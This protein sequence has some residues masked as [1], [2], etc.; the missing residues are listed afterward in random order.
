MHRLPLLDMLKRYSSRYPDEAEMLAR[1]RHLVESAPDCFQRTCRPGH[2]TGSAWV[3]SHD[4]TKCLLLHH[5]KL[6]RWLQPGG[7]ADGQTEIQQ[8][9]LR[10]A[11]EES[12]LTQLALLGDCQDLVPLDI[13][14]HKIPARFDAA[15]N[16]TEDAHEHHDIRFLV[17][18]GANQ[19][20]VLSEESHDLRWFTNQ[21]VLQVTQEESVLRM[22]RKAGPHKNG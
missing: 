8:V 6:D 16:M 12:G 5:R 15:G 10:E 3:L 22:M 20:L 7:H 9:A 11:E 18:A 2:I 19:E 14:V 13:D 17:V 21:E 1:I 4:R